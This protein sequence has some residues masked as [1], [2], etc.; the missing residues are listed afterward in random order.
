MILSKKQATLWLLG[1]LSLFLFGLVSV[2]AAPV[3]FT[4]NTSGNSM[5][6]APAACPGRGRF[7]HYHW[8][9]NAQ[10]QFQ[11]QRTEC[12]LESGRIL[13]RR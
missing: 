4:A 1:A 2:S 5:R 3:T 9:N 12:G 7:R 8:W 6:A 10:L 11:T 13:Q